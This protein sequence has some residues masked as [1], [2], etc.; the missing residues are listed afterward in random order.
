MRDGLTARQ[1]RFV[2][3]YC[4]SL[5]AT[6][7]AIKAGYSEKGADSWGSQLLSNP[8]V[9]AEI[10]KKMGKVCNKLE[11][12]AQRVLEEI[13][14]LAFY[15]PGDFFQDDGSLKGIKELD[16]DTRRAIAGL[17]VSELFEG[18]DVPD[19]PQQKT[20][21]GLLKKVKLSDK[22]AALELLGK[23]LKLFTDKQEIAHSGT[24]NL[25]V[26]TLNDFYAGLP[27]KK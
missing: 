23:Y 8:K 2:V 18:K 17:E 7:A 11:I 6:S 16:S 1:A 12:S 4:V 25:Q 19:G 27:E 22:R 15:D 24:V 14:K 9:C 26:R 5:N 20:I 3:E 13:A 21:Y 10:A